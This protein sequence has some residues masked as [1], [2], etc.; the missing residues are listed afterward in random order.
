M[1]KLLL[2][3]LLFFVPISM[4]NADLKIAIVDLNKAFD[5]Y[6]KTKQGSARLDEKATT[7]KKEIQDSMGDFQRMQDEAKKLYDAANDQTLSQA[8]RD[9]KKKAL[10]A[11][12]QDLLNMRNKIQEMDT[13]RSNELKDEQF[14][15][16]KEIVDEIN[17]VITDYSGPQGFDL[18][19]DKS[20]LS[21]ASGAPI[22][23]FNS[24]K[25]VDITADI[26]SKLN[27]GA[28][29]ATAPAPSGAAPSPAP[30]AQ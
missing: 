9:D 26:I 22:L 30:A 17:K 29:P 8:A 16:R 12:N 19:I 2:L 23:L 15:L 14:R 7:Y 13:E 6:Y 24:N 4:A 3:C 20:A 27:A 18:V 5:Q 10:E 28:P 1:N 21:A 25:L 11:K